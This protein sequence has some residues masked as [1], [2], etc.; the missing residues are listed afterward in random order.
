MKLK[1]NIRQD[2]KIQEGDG[3]RG[4]KDRRS[5]KL[6]PVARMALEQGGNTPG[7]FQNVLGD[8]SVKLAYVRSGLALHNKRTFLH[9]ENGQAA[10]YNIDP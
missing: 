9:A 5:G 6:E 1:K 7:P 3:D 4:R 10:I 2:S 8:A